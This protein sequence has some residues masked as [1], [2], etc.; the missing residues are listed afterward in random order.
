MTSLLL[1]KLNRE[2]K[3]SLITIEQKT[4]EIWNVPRH[5]YFTG[6]DNEHAMRVIKHIETLAKNVK[7]TPDERYVLLAASFLHDIG[8][9]LESGG[10]N[11]E[12]AREVH[13]TAAAQWIIDSVDESSPKKS[14]GI[15]RVYADA[16]A[17]VV[18]GHR[19][20]E[21]ES[22]KFDDQ[23]VNSGPIRVR[24]LSALL[25][26]ADEL[27]LDHNRVDEARLEFQE[28]SVESK[29]HWYKHFFI[30]SV[31]INSNTHVIRVHWKFRP[32]SG[33]APDSCQRLIAIP[34]QETL[35]KKI[36]YLKRF[37]VP[38]DVSFLLEPMRVDHSTSQ[39]MLP[40][41]IRDY[42]VGKR[43][44]DYLREQVEDA[45][46]RASDSAE[47]D[48]LLTTDSLRA[49]TLAEEGYVQAAALVLEEIG[50][51]LSKRRQNAGAATK[52]E[53]AA[54]QFERASLTDEA[55]RSLVQAARAH[56]AGGH[57]SFAEMALERASGL[58]TPKV[59]LQVKAELMTLRG[60]I[61]LGGGDARTARGY[62]EEAKRLLLEGD[63]KDV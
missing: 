60:R 24:F 12:Q 16:I 58:I 45:K 34:V 25:Q 17:T 4:E 63:S 40:Q 36:E 13:E 9:Q 61:V 22:E 50:D 23:H 44:F 21:I 8:M 56:L 52:Y 15:V 27:D 10:L 33:E 53:E 28:A 43:R 11:D 14:I 46:A 47:M 1:A 3:T 59:S 6:H 62:F 42:L 29:S 41:D 54:D 39:L 18:L 7:L 19:S 38:H 26:L 37:L 32:E 57:F 55:S 2:L 31:E 49:H 51:T 5:R 20:R 48:A 30:V 35:G